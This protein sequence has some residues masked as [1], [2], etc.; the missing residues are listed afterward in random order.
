MSYHFPTCI[1]DTSQVIQDMIET[2]EEE[3]TEITEK[4]E[5]TENNGENIYNWTM[6]IQVLTERLRKLKEDLSRKQK[7]EMTSK[8]TKISEKLARM[9]ILFDT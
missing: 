2:C 9:K 7:E 8:R 5:S 3:L 1:T 6:R 4:I